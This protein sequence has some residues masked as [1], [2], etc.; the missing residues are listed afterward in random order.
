[1]ISRR[2]NGVAN[3]MSKIPGPGAYEPKLATKKSAPAFKIGTSLRDQ[4]NKSTSNI[5]GAG[6]YNPGWNDRPKSPAFKIGSDTR[7]PL[8][9]FVYTPGPG[10]YNLPQRG[11]EGPQLS[12]KGVPDKDP[13]QRERERVPGA[14]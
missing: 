8:N 7:K 5:P 10:T 11:I 14:G 2:Q 3:E 4:L 6:S 12:F 13:V 1:M 9:G